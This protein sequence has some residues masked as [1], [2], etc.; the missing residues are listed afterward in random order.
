MRGT[1]FSSNTFKTP[2][3]TCL[4]YEIY[5]KRSHIIIFSSYSVMVRVSVVLR[6]HP[7]DHTVRTTDT[8]GFKP[9]TVIIIFLLKSNFGVKDVNV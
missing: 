7:D 1:V 9:F 6:R 5:V 3:N 8:P 2:G 4:N